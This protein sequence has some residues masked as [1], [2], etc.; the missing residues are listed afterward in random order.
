MPKNTLVSEQLN[1]HFEVSDLTTEQIFNSLTLYIYSFQNKQNDLHI[2][3]KLLPED[4]II[5][6]VAYFDGDYLKIPTKEDYQNARLLALTFFLKEVQKWNWA[7]IKDFLNIGEEDKDFFSTISLGKKMSTIKENLSFDIKKLLGNID[8][9][10]IEDI[11]RGLLYT[12]E[13]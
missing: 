7:E 1:K 5:K 11:L 3:A 4:L 2:L 6:I 10:E 13:K 9:K 12:N 8:K